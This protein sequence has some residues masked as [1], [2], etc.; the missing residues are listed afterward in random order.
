MAVV[1]DFT[2]GKWSSA[3]EFADFD[4]MSQLNYPLKDFVL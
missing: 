4:V 2:H 1:R 3:C